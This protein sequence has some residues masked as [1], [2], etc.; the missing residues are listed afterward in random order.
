MKVQN[1]KFVNFYQV[2]SAFELHSD[3]QNET[4]SNRIRYAHC[5]VKPPVVFQAGG[6]I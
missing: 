3:Q 4:P 6:G 2:Q 5:Q 1:T